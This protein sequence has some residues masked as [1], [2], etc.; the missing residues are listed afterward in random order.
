[1]RLFVHLF[2]DSARPGLC[3]GCGSAVT[4]WDAC[5]GRRVAIAVEAA[6]LRTAINLRHH[7]FVS[8]FDRSAVHTDR[9]SGAWQFRSRRRPDRSG[10]QQIDLFAG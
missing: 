7:R 5:N 10:P 4:W 9:C 3:R 2:A 6:P 1:V 8:V